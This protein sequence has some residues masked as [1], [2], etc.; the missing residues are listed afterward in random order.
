MKNDMDTVDHIGE[1][2]NDQELN[3][4]KRKYEE[5]PDSNKKFFDD[6][7]TS[8]DNGEDIIK[9]SLYLP[10]KVS[11]FD[12]ST[13]HEY[14]KSCLS[15]FFDNSSPLRTPEIYKEYRDFMINTYQQ[16]PSQYLT[17]TGCRRNLVGDAVSIYKVHSFLEKEGL[18]NYAIL[19]PILPFDNKIVNGD[20]E[21]S[22]KLDQMSSF[23]E[24][25][26]MKQDTWSDEES[27]KLLEAI[28]LYGE[29]WNKISQHVGTKS[30]EQCILQF[31]QLP[32][33]ENYLRANY[34]LSEKK[35][36]KEVNPLL[37]M[38]MFLKDN[39][40]ED[41][42]KEASTNAIKF[43]AKFA[44]LKE[45][46]IND[47]LKLLSRSEKDK[48]N[49]QLAYE[50]FESKIKLIE[51]RIENICDIENELIKERE[52]IKIERKKL[53]EEKFLWKE[54]NKNKF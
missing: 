39:S 29:S 49:E 23:K 50:N 31:I 3:S 30:P 14:E 13:I 34:I 15:E 5:H 22:Y 54:E 11:W 28:D 51:K 20:T 41:D 10:S 25:I 52:N 6:I 32:I 33:E 53:L 2:K 17:F 38:M 19:P 48:I 8:I 42:I 45:E 27:N 21:T 26:K 44:N 1:K 46:N 40:I 12:I 7:V 24:Y 47:I 18:I 36:E 9:P 35:K 43:F 16:N 4:K 37:T